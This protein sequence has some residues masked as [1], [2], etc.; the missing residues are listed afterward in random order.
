MWLLGALVVLP[1]ALLAGP[2]DNGE[3]L[4]AVPVVAGMVLGAVAG[5]IRSADSF[6]EKPAQRQIGTKGAAARAN[7]LVARFTTD[8]GG[9]MRCNRRRITRRHIEGA[10]SCEDCLLR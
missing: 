5:F 4:G 2:I 8:D 3:G 6:V 7:R 1:Y 9:E 10:T